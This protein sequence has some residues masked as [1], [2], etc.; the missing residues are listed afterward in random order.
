LSLG[1]KIEVSYP[2]AIAAL[3][4]PG[5]FYAL[6]WLDLS[7][8]EAKDLFSVILNVSAIAAG[9][10]GTAASVLLTIGPA[11]VIRDLKES[12]SLG[13]LYQYVIAAIRHQFGLVLFSATLLVLYPKLHSPRILYCLAVTWGVFTVLAALSSFRIIQ[14]FGKIITAE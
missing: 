12:G 11:A 8:Q 4:A 7:T 2:Y 6:R 10:L 14:L 9:F 3:S 1:R 5:W 13:L